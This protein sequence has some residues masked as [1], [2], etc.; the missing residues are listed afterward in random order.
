[1]AVIG[2][3]KAQRRLETSMAPISTTQVLSG[4]AGGIP[5]MHPLK[6]SGAMPNLGSIMK[7]PTVFKA[8]SKLGQARGLK[9]QRMGFKIPRLGGGMRLPKL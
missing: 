6:G 2:P 1:M 9:M 3:L 7:M 5:K 8:S 4:Q